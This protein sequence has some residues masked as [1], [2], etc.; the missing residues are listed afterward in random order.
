MHMT[1]AFQYIAWPG[2][3][4]CLVT[5]HRARPRKGEVAHGARGRPT[6]RMQLS[7]RM[8]NPKVVRATS[9][10]HECLN[11]GREF[12]SLSKGGLAGFWTHALKQISS[13]S[14][15]Q[16]THTTPRWQ[17]HNPLSYLNKNKSYPPHYHNYIGYLW[18]WLPWKEPTPKKGKQPVAEEALD[19]SCLIY[20]EL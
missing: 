6:T 20:V 18:H 11:Q 4:H 14:T 19:H 10:P 16:L 12:E 2:D 3:T 13:T 1:M 8:Q 7:G 15:H 17:G 5:T 9:E